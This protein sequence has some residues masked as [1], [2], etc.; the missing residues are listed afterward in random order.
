MTVRVGDTLNIN[1]AG[2]NLTAATT[3]DTAVLKWIGGGGGMSSPDSEHYVFTD[4]VAREPG[5]AELFAT[6]WGDG[7][8]PNPPTSQSEP[9][10]PVRWTMQVHVTS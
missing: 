2:D 1:F 5:R 10:C 9:G 3:T 7:A 6:Y 4:Y 8:C